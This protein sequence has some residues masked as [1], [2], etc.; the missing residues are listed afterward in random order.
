MGPP[1]LKVRMYR[2]WEQGL[3]NENTRI[4]SLALQRTRCVLVH[5]SLN[6]SVPQLS[7]LLSG[8]KNYRE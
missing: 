8:G 5:K 2:G 4:Q 7:H 1:R 3:G 6:L